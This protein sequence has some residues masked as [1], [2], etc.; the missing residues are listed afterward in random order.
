MI[1]KI[2]LWILVILWMGLI[3]YFS[4]F[5]SEKSTKQSKGFLYHTLGIVIDFFD[6]DIS[7]EEKEI[8]IDKLDHPIRKIAH[9]SV[10]F[11]LGL[12]VC[13]ALNEYSFNIK[14]LLIISFIICFSY[15]CSDEIH[16]LFISGRSG[17]IKDVIIDTCGF[18]LSLL[19]F[20]C[21]K[22]RNKK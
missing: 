2:V 19:T 16:Q 12:L 5:N 13:L 1:K 8:I 11:I 21:F 3:F 9:A 7:L 22:S 14:K 17:E 10:Y 4:S 18:S 20:Y 6:K 15:A